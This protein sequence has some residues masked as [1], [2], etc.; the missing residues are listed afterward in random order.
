MNLSYNEI[1]KVGKCTDYALCYADK[2]PLWV[3]TWQVNSLDYYAIFSDTHNSIL[4]ITVTPHDFLST[5]PNHS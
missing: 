1:Q 4:P 2:T 3:E 5:R